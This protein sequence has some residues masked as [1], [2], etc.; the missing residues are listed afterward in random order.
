VRILRRGYPGGRLE[1]HDKA[2]TPGHEL[3]APGLEEIVKTRE[4]PRWTNGNLPDE[5]W[6]AYAR[7][8]R[9]EARCPAPGPRPAGK[10]SRYAD[11][12]KVRFESRM[13]GLSSIPP[14]AGL[15]LVA[16]LA[17]SG[18]SETA[19]QEADRKGEPTH[20]CYLERQKE[21]PGAIKEE[22]QEEHADEVQE[23]VEEVE[24]ILKREQAE[25]TA[26]TLREL[27]GR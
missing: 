23:E 24:E 14:L 18:C 2:R 17:F 7:A 21:E 27:E 9:L 19:C 10:Q 5:W 3:P 15:A 12:I 26:Q 4:A 25:E 1:D 16:L 8:D 22:E 6:T 20:A 13:G 11:Q